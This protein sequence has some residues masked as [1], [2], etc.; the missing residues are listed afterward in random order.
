MSQTQSARRETRTCCIDCEYGPRRLKPYGSGQRRRHRTRRR[1]SSL[2]PRCEV[3][4]HLCIVYSA[5]EHPSRRQPGSP[6][7]HTALC[8]YSAWGE[9][10]QPPTARVSASC[11]VHTKQ[12]LKRAALEAHTL[13]FIRQLVQTLAQPPGQ[14]NLQRL[15]PFCPC[16]SLRQFL[17]RQEPRRRASMAPSRCCRAGQ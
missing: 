6:E 9:C 5:C 7:M 1:V 15:T 3:L 2:L 12:Q 14:V 10:P 13:N 17:P 16:D 11:A 4:L 8:M